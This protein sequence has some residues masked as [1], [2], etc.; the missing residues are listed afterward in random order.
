MEVA[1]LPAAAAKPGTYTLDVA[2]AAKQASAGAV[3][4][5][6]QT[7]LVPL[8]LAGERST[9][10]LLGGTHVPWS[11]P[12]DS[13][14]NS[15]LPLLR[16]MGMP[17]EATLNRWGWYPAGQGEIACRI[18]DATIA[19]GATACPRP[20]ALDQRGALMCIDG[21]SVVA[22]LPMH[23][24]RR[25]AD[26]A[27]S[28]LAELN[29]P[30][31]LSQEC[32]DS[33]CPGAGI[34][35]TAHYERLCVCFSALGLR[36]KPAE[37]VAAD[38]ARELTAHHASGAA[39]D[40]HLA[41]QLLLPLAVASAPSSFTTSRPSRHLITNAWT[42]EQFGTAKILIDAGTPTHVHVYP[43]GYRSELAG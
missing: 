43:L 13:L 8:A 34:F 17:V 30:L 29:V 41:D 19:C 26:E 42:I 2:A 1:F 15:Y 27:S 38:A 40:V 23:I 21:R 14:L 24:A 33:A 10:V 25:M 4:L 9:L 3:T 5:I 36:G 20:I 31:A 18:G 16:V 32:V 12:C 7:L 39:V 22:N 6:L 28:R 37:V 35:L 11:P